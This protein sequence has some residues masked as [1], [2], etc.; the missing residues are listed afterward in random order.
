MGVDLSLSLMV[1][2][3]MY[4]GE[5]CKLPSIDRVQGKQKY[6]KTDEIMHHKYVLMK[7]VE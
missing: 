7:G 2:R 6:V 3:H 5:E 1:P 4:S